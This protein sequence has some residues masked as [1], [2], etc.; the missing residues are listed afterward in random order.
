MRIPH[1]RMRETASDHFVVLVDETGIATIQIGH[2]HCLVTIRTELV[3]RVKVQLPRAADEARM[4]ASIVVH[5]ALQLHN[6]PFARVLYSLRPF[7]FNLNVP[8]CHGEE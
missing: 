6:V 8:T 7:V 3:T 1:D 2:R 4:V 5:S